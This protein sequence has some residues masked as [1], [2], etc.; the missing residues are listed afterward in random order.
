[1]IIQLLFLGGSNKLLYVRIILFQNK[2]MKFPN[3]IPTILNDLNT[4][5]AMTCYVALEKIDLS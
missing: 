1:M 4:E 5:R 2:G 3:S